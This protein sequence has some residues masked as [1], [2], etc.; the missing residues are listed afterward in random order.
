MNKQARIF[1]I[2]TLTPLA[3]LIPV[4]DLGFIIGVPAFLG[5]AWLFGGLFK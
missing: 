4:G 1:G 5:A 3:F 2:I